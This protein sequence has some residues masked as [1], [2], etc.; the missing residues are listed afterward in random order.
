MIGSTKLYKA[1]ISDHLRRSWTQGIVRKTYDLALGPADGSN[2]VLNEIVQSRSGDAEYAGHG[3]AA[4][5]EG[6]CVA[7]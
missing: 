6:G 3:R 7:K 5:H 2:P 1:S 4:L